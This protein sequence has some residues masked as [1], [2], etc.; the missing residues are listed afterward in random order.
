MIPKGQT[1]T[2]KINKRDY[3]L[4]GFWT[5]KETNKIRTQPVEWKKRNCKS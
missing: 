5:A 3:K 4:K 1:T 2:A